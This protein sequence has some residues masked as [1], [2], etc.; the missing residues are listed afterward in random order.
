MNL[1]ISR[2][3]WLPASL[4]NLMLEFLDFIVSLVE[5]NKPFIPL[6]QRQTNLKAEFFL[7]SPEAG[8]SAILL[9]PHLLRDFPGCEISVLADHLSPERKAHFQNLIPELS[10]QVR[11]IE[12]KDIGLRSDHSEKFLISINQA[13]LFSDDELMA[14][15]KDFQTKFDQILIGEGNN[16]SGRQVIGMLILAPLVAI[17]C[18]PFVKPFRLLRLVFTFL[19]PLL[20]LMIAWDG[21]VALFKIRSPE[22]LKE[23]M[24]SDGTDGWTWK[25]GK[26]PNNRGGFVIF[27]QGIRSARHS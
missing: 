14:R 21:I 19:I 10:S 22:R 23:L 6:L 20:P 2:S 17:V 25:V 9:V 24:T 15:L 13:H 18:A 3:K 27:L 26:S 11:F 16:K 4:K 8:G 12:Q 7:D 5:A 1:Q